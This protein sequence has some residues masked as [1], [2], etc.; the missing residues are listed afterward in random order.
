[1][2][3]LAVALGCAPLLLSSAPALAA[4][5][6]VGSSLSLAGAVNLPTCPGG[7][8]CVAFTTNN[9]APVAVSPYDGVVTVWRV[10]AG[11]NASPVKLR[12]LRPGAG[13]SYTAVGTSETK[14]TSGQAAPDEYPSNILVDKGDVL[15]LGNDSSA[16]L[17]A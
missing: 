15:A 3:K 13:G 5:T 16:L 4:S 1:M 10:R 2:R 7:F 6:T 14:M 11:S 17:Y 9:G 8:D 12:I